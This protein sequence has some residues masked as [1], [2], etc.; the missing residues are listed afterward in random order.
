MNSIVSI[1]IASAVPVAAPAM[2]AYDRRALEAYASWLHMERRLLCLEL[3]P[4]MGTAAER[5]VWADNAGHDW[6]FRGEGHWRDLPQPS[7]RAAAVLDLVGVDWKDTRYGGSSPRDDGQRPPLPDNWPATKDPIFAAIEAHKA[8]EAEYIKVIELC[9]DVETASAAEEERS[10]SACVAT[11]DAALQLLNV[12]P[13]TLAGVLA[14]LRYATESD[15][16][17]MEFPCEVHSGDDRDIVR[18]WQFFLI[19]NVATALARIAA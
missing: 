6:H 12:A 17:G 2:P 10:Y 11:N 9:E 7:T 4:Q 8:A 3:W 19:E 16:D 13:T 14:L 18:S 15:T 5:Y 1:A